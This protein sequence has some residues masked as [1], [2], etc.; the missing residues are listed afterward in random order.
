[1]LIQQLKDLQ[2][3][4]KVEEDFIVVCLSVVAHIIMHVEKNLALEFFAFQ[5]THYYTTSGNA[6]Y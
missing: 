1:M 5:Q 3:L 4:P 6:V 2:Q